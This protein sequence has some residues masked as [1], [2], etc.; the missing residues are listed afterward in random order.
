MRVETVLK[1]AHFSCKIF[2]R[3]GVAHDTAFINT[4]INIGTHDIDMLFLAMLF[5]LAVA[6]LE[7]IAYYQIHI[8]DLIISPSDAYCC[9]VSFFLLFTFGGQGNIHK[10]LAISQHPGQI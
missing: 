3:L 7:T 1:F 4:L 6:K 10:H 2:A 9:S 5:E 8:F